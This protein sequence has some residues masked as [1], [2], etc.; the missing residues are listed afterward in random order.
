MSR[1][2]SRAS[3]REREARAD[4]HPAVACGSLAQGVNSWVGAGPGRRF[5][6]TRSR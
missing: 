2:A 4:R 5:R 6:P 1:K 3:I